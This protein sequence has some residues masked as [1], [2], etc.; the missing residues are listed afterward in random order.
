M[1]FS[2]KQR[3]SDAEYLLTRAAAEADHAARAASMRSAEIHHQLAS[4]Y[5]DRVFGDVGN[6]RG[7]LQRHGRVQACRAMF[8]GIRERIARQPADR[9]PEHLSEL[10]ERLSDHSRGA[11]PAALA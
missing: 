5:L 11:G 7:L 3:I 4:A 2:S 9:I 10:L 1:A 6:E 8:I